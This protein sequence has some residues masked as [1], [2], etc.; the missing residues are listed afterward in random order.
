MRTMK[1]IKIYDGIHFSFT[2]FRS[3]D[4]LEW[5]ETIPLT[6]SVE[7]VQNKR[8]FNEILFLHNI[9]VMYKYTFF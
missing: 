6:T 5:K 8:F 3:V 2:H 4:D 7:K 9:H 1:Q